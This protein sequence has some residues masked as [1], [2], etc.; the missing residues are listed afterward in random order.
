MKTPGRSASSMALVCAKVGGTSQTASS[1]SAF[2]TRKRRP[3]PSDRGAIFLNGWDMEYLNSD[4][5]VFGLG[6][7]IFNISRLKIPP[8]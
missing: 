5:H 3:Q 7:V 6:S 4:H 8:S 2:R 1:A